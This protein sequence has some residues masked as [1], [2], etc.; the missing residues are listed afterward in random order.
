MS[1]RPIRF[2]HASDFH[3]ELP[4]SGV[5]ELPDSLR[6]LFLEAAY[7]AAARVFDAA[8]GVDADF[9]VLAGDIFDLGRAGPRAPLFLSEQ[10][11]RLAERGIQVYW[12]GG[13]VDPPDDWPAWAPLPQNVHLFP[14]GSV[15]DF[16]H[17]HDGVPTARLVGCSWDRQRPVP[18]SA[19]QRDPTGLV[20]IGVTFGEYDAELLQSRHLHYWALG[21]RHARTTISGAPPAAHYSG[22]PQGRSPLD[23]G[24]HGCTLVQIDDEQVHTSLVPCDAARWLNLRVAIDQSTAR[25]E[26]ESMLRQQ[27]RQC[28]EGLPEARMLVS[29]TIAGEGPLL[30]QL[31]RGGLAAELLAMLRAA[32][33]D[34]TTAPWSVSLTAEPTA[35]IPAECYDEDTI[36]GDFLRALR[37][38][39]D[40]PQLP[41]PHQGDWHDSPSASAL[42][43]QPVSPDD[44]A[45]QRLLREAA[46]LGM[47]LLS[48][49]EPSS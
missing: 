4:L 48:G 26:L 2:I 5:S 29:W 42:D 38:L 27:M 25:D 9:L 17:T 24:S 16:T 14:R 20:T 45:R 23:V 3:L 18:L 31:R 46:F 22:T 36:R 37:D 33:S 35:A 11:D 47:E 30:K 1:T 7:R 8:V 44:S 43:K 49:E 21:G 10:F 40:D 32:S 19:F 15:T 12:C 6:D 34:S 13:Q 41:L 39:E 28:C